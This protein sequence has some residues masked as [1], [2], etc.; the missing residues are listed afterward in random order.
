MEWFVDNW[1]IVI[2]T[3]ATLIVAGIMINKFWRLPKVDKFKKIKT[4]LLAVVIEAEKIYGGN[5]GQ[6]K[7]SY[8]YGL[9]KENFPFTASFISFE[10]FRDIV[11][12]VLEK[13]RELLS[14]NRELRKYIESK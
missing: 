14:E 12:S 8:V 5:T 9:F 6:A 11:D 10:T 2:I 13:M 4:W 1:Y 7:L 3:I